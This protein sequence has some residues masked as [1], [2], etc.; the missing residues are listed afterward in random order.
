MK[1]TKRTGL[2]IVLSSPSGAGKSTLARRL[3]AEDSQLTLSVS[4]TTRAPR[5][6]E[7]D[8]KDY[9]FVSKNGFQ[10][11]IGTGDLLE[12]AEVF[13]NFYGTPLTPVEETI[14]TGRDVL[15]D[16]DWQGAQQIRHSRLGHAVVSLFILPPSIAALEARLK[17]RAQD[18]EEVIR[19]RMAKALDEISHWA[20]Y[21]YVLINDNLDACYS[22]IE[23]V[24]TAE[25]LRLGR[26]PGVKSHVENLIREFKER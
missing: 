24:I 18:S 5:P 1:Q 6:G 23:T 11:M 12:Y 26:Q 25:R 7:I 14:G 2:L 20:E 10:T 13:G 8:G 16:V 17:T 9:R 3:I 22:Q 21:D 15:L 4:A 19:G